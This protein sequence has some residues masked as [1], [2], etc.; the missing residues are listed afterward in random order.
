MEDLAM[1]DFQSALE[2]DEKILAENK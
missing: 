1:K 2:I